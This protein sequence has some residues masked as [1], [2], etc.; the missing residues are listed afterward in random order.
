MADMAAYAEAR[1]L[2][3]EPGAV[4]NYSSG[5][6]N[7]VAAVVGRAVDDVRRF[8]HDRVLHPIGMSSADPR[9]D[10]AGTFV[11]SSYLYATAR[12]WARFG[13]LY[14]RD[15]VWDRRRLL[16]EGWVDHG[17]T[18]RSVDPEDGDLYGA[19]WWVDPWGADVGS[20]RAS[21]FEGQTVTVVPA[22]DAVVVR[23]G[24]TPEEQ[25]D[26]LTDWRRRA[27]E[28]LG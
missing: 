25:H 22:L 28:A 4:F 10:D 7:I 20:F 23:L 18:V 11:G 9:V 3:H 15:G 19:H 24:K 1:P 13:T 26:A 8:L 16:P 6:S 5:T 2:A 21:G 12:D 17:R 14:L 27:V